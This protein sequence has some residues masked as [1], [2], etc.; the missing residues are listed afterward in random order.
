[1]QG[2]TGGLEE[3]GTGVEGTV[4]TAHV[5]VSTV[6]MKRS[7]ADVLAVRKDFFDANKAVVE[8]LAAGYL[9]GCDDL[10]Q[11]KAKAGK[12]KDAQAKYKAVLKLTQ[13]IYGKE[14]IRTE[15]DADGLI[16][17]A[18]F[19]G[20]PG[21][22]A[23]FQEKGNLSGFDAKQKQA[24]DLAVGEKYAEARPPSC[25]S[26]STTKRSPSSGT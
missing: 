5:L 19:V 22:R 26:P 7:I 20:L 2:L 9:K 11:L 14:T 8:K 15:D 13:D 10:L 24:L 6:N 4:K 12:D 25:P 17:D 18:V 23:F 21:N 16:S 1:M 3:R